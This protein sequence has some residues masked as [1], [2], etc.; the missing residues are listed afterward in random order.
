ME[1]TKRSIRRTRALYRTKWRNVVVFGVIPVL[2]LLN[3]GGFGSPVDLDLISDIRL[4]QSS[5]FRY[6]R[7]AE[8]P[9]YVTTASPAHAEKNKSGQL[10]P[11]DL[12]DLQQR[13]EGW[14]VLYIM[15]VMYMFVAL[16]IVCDEFFVPSL[17]VII[18]K[19]DIQ[20]SGSYFIHIQYSF[21]IFPQVEHFPTLT[22]YSY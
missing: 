12:F 13:R 7:Q 2:L 22:L 17:D 15:G 14:V 1:S 19:L 16:A 8:F 5:N 9:D 6:A 21:L 3:S 4:Y 10:F 11:P 20:V 18:E